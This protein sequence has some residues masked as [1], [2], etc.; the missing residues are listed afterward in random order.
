MAELD[1]EI[2]KLNEKTLARLSAL[3]KSKVYI[4]E[5][6]VTGADVSVGTEIAVNFKSVLDSLGVGS[7]II[8]NNN[9]EHPMLRITELSKYLE[10]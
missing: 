2:I 4:I 3:D 10:K 1:S 8:P 9:F 7:V 5:V 6:D